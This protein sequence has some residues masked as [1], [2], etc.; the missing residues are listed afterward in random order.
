MET[1]DKPA[2][3]IIGAAPMCLLANLHFCLF[4]FAFCLAANV[5]VQKKLATYADQPG[6]RP[7]GREITKARIR[8]R[9]RKEIFDGFGE[10]A[11][12]ANFFAHKWLNDLQVGLVSH[13]RPCLHA[14]L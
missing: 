10:T 4:T 3:V 11:Y 1:D 9:K 8:G 13:P 5:V 2:L 14:S 7:A 12:L 6:Q